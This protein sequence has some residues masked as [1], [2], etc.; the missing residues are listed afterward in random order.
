MHGIWHY[1]DRGWMQCSWV[2]VYTMSG[3]QAWVIVY[4]MSSLYANNVVYYVYIIQEI[5]SKEPTFKLLDHSQFNNL[6]IQIAWLSNSICDIFSYMQGDQLYMV[7]CFW[8]PVKVICPV[9]GCTSLEK[10]HFTRFCQNTAMFIWSGCN[11]VDPSTAVYTT[12]FYTCIDYRYTS[13]ICTNK[14]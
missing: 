6:I 2:I 5:S 9:Y 14:E 13:I 3:V 11:S 1:R 4:T 7:L 12:W 10:P 8:Y